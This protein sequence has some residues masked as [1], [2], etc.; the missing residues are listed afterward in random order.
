VAGRRDTGYLPRRVLGRDLFA[1]A[2]R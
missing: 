1:W 2:G